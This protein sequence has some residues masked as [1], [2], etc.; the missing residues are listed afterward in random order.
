MLIE[1]LKALGEAQRG[2]MVADCLIK[3][4]MRGV[5]THGVY[6]LKTIANR[7]KE[8]ILKLPT[9]PEI[10][11]NQDATAVVDG[12]NGLGPVAGH[13]AV[14]VCIEKAR[15]FGIGMVLIR[16][17]NNIGSLA[18]Y[19]QLASEQNMI[20]FMSTNA[21]PS[22]APWGGSEPFIGTNPIAISIPTPQGMCFTVDMASS[23]VARGKIRKALRQDTKIPDNWALDRNGVPTTDPNEALMGTLIPIGG[24]K[25]AAIALSVD[26]IAGILAGSSYGRMVKSFHTLEGPTGVGASYI[27]IDINHFMDFTRFQNLLREYINS[28]KNISKANGFI[29]IFLPGEIEYRKEQNSIKQGIELDAQTVENLTELMEKINIRKKD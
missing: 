21:A 15:Q 27:A 5:N 8:G 3:A 12:K 23:V 13:I 14:K 6:L 16:N 7:V 29:E 4:D 25:G 2:R 10:I 9:E 18:Y 28:V 22:M 19:T 17:T 20:A 11:I 1:I 24:P 26:I